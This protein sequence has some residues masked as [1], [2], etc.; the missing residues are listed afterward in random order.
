M[1][2]PTLVLIANVYDVWRD[3]GSGP[4][5]VVEA[6]GSTTYVVFGGARLLGG[7]LLVFGLAALYLYQ[8]EAAGKLGLGGFVISMVGTVLLTGSAWYQ[9]FVVPVMA[10]EVPAFAEA[11]RAADAG[12]LLTLGLAIPLFAQAIGWTIFGL[13]T[14][15]A[16]VFP[17]WAAVGVIVGALLLLVPIPGIPVVFQLAVAS[18]GLLLLSG[19]LENPSHEPT[20]DGSQSESI[21]S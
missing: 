12:A 1:L 11:A 3:L 7:I 8:I 9:L 10:A 6:A 18:M 16:C 19:R 14:Y 20:T 21:G 17:R 4:E 5:S 15:R 13:A 2:G